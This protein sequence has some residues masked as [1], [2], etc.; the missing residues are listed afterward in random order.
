MN[1]PGP[2]DLEPDWLTETLRSSAAIS[3]GT[4]VAGVYL[5][6]IGQGA[7]MMSAL[8]RLHLQYEGAAPGPAS[9]IVKSP[10]L[11]ETNRAVATSFHIYEREARFFK[12]LAPHCLAR[13]PKVHC[14]E[15]DDEQNFIL[16]MEDLQDYRLGDQ[17]AGA[18]LAETELCLEQL[19]RL[20]ASFWN[21]VEGLAWVPLIEGSTHA[22][23]YLR[24]AEHGW[25]QTER[26]FGHVIPK[27]IPSLMGR[28][29]AVLPRLQKAL[30]TAPLTLIH[31]D[32][33][34]ENLFFGAGAHQAPLVV[35]D[36]QGPLLS[37]GID[38]VAFFLA[39][40]A[41]TEVR[42]AHE[43]RLVRRYVERL[44]ELGVED[45]DFESC[46][47]DYR[48]AVLYNWGYVILVSG[49]LDSSD[50]HARAW[51]TEMVRRNAVAI[52]DLD[53]LEFL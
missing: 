48:L 29:L 24:G 8:G 5:E 39:Q 34:L 22:N 32:F 21:A 44:A 7:G 41:Q 51:M 42:R 30:A 37:R 49:T 25:P 11:N 3:E 18:G 6:A 26:V 47:R 33:R 52:E 14:C 36:W 2:G 17:V 43:R 4:R 31:G 35:I 20:H 10:A 19:A 1:I 28:F 13:T 9:L 53:A 12:E 46:W 45:G 27:S 38:D 50:P 40:N 15:I 23:N 16:L